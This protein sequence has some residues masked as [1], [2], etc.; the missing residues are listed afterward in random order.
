MTRDPILLAV[1]GLRIGGTERQLVELL[2]GMRHGGRHRIVLSVLDHGGE[3]EAEAVANAAA[4]LPLRRRARFDCTPA[5]FL[6]WQARR[7]RVRLI[8]AVGRMSGLAGLAVA[9][10][11]GVPLVNGSIRAA[12]APLAPR[13][14]LSRWCA[15]RSDW[16]VANSRAGLIAHGLGDHPR[17]QVIANGIDLARFDRVV[18][19]DGDEPTIC[20]VANFNVRKDHVTVIRALALVRAAI[21]A[22]RLVLVGG[23]F[24]TLAASRHLAHSLGVGDAVRFV[25]DTAHPESFIAASRVCVLTSPSESLSN[26]IMEYMALAK[27]VIASDTCG[28]SAALLHDGDS[29]FLVPPQA[30]DAVAERIIGLLR[31][32]P[33]ARAMGAAARRR[34][35]EFSITRMVAAYEALFDRLLTSAPPARTTGQ[36]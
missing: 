26:A 6:L 11:L 29:G 36:R 20:M 3:L 5:L 27:P 15:V 28:D 24:G 32:P 1:D 13:D 19:A 22:A 10:A 14:R 34:V 16:I 9:R 4:V 35:Q 7:A 18:A 8:H 21:P 25:T 23:D 31:D 17:A 12:P 30:P 2:K 33:R